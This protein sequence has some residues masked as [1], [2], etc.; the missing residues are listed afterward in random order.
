MTL[1]CRAV[2]VLPAIIEHATSHSI[3]LAKIMH[4]D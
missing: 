1:S 3:M 2:G 4:C